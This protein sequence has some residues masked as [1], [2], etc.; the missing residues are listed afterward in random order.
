MLVEGLGEGEETKLESG[1][2]QVLGSRSS[3]IRSPVCRSDG[4]SGCFQLNDT[5]E[6]GAAGPSFLSLLHHPVSFMDCFLKFIR[7]AALFLLL[8]LLYKFSVYLSLFSCIF[9]PSSP[10]FL[11]VLYITVVGLVPVFSCSSPTSMV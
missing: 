4:I 6:G 5:Q 3:F 8:P 2:D 10:S 7:L 9:H 11:T 1:R